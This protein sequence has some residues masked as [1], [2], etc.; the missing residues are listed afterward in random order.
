MLTV[1]EK[2]ILWVNPDCGL[3]TRKY[4]KVK[5]QSSQTW[6]PD[7][8]IRNELAKH[9]LHIVGE[10]QL[11]INHCLLGLPGVRKED[12]KAVMSHPQCKAAKYMQMKEL[13]KYK[14]Q[15]QVVA[16]STKKKIDKPNFNKTRMKDQRN[17]LPREP[18]YTHYTP[19]VQADII[20]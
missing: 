9:K 11:L 2:N 12:L 18:C 20:S 5:P 8:L 3:K 7:K 1:L 15:V 13:T 4:T 6:L 17:Q 14:N 19:Q 10:V 16:T